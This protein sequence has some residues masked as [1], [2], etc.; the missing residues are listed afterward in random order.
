MLNI[1]LIIRV[2]D[3]SAISIILENK[4]VPH[5]GVS[6]LFP[7]ID[8]TIEMIANQY[9]IHSSYVK[10]KLI[11]LLVKDNQVYA[12]YTIL[13]PKEFLNENVINK[14]SNNFGK[15]SEQDGIAVRQAI[16]VFPY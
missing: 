10:P 15:L 11:T 12:Y 1:K 2:I 14:L 7:N 5:E 13:T 9:N 16:S 8:E 4:E 6:N 3:G